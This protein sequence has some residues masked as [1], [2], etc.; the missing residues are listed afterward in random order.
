ME[1]L[2]S[3]AAIVS[4]QLPNAKIKVKLTK[5]LGEYGRGG[6]GISKN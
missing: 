6:R 1:Q 5:Y 3:L 4:F 2:V